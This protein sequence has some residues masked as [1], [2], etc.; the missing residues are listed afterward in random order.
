MIAERAHRVEHLHDLE[1][2]VTIQ[3]DAALDRETLADWHVGARDR[4]ADAARDG[5]WDAVLTL[6]RESEAQLS[7]NH[8]RVGG[9]SWF[10]PLHQAAYHGAPISVVLQL[11]ELG[12]SRRLPTADGRTPFDIAVSAAHERLLPILKPEIR[13]PAPVDVLAVL[14]RRLH[15]LVESRVR[16]DIE[17][18]LRPL[19]TAMLTELAEGTTVWFPIPGMLGGFS[20]RLVM[21]YLDVR[22]WSRS[23]AGSGQAHVI[24]VDG[25]TLVAE[26]FV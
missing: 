20:V 13:N 10:T 6:L 21:S 9:P 26:G 24:T 18:R 3:W 15:A 2:P 16:P 19:P 11:V 1:V 14:D 17:V 8:W 5:R 12:G 4:L 7:P 25:T 22:S 23:S